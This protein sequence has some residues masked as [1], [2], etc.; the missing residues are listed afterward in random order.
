[1]NRASVFIREKLIG[2][3]GQAFFAGIELQATN[4][5]SRSSL[6]DSPLKRGKVLNILGDFAQRR[7]VKCFAPAGISHFRLQVH[8]TTV[9]WLQIAFTGRA[10]TARKRFR[11]PQKFAQLPIGGNKSNMFLRDHFSQSVRGPLN[12]D[13]NLIFSWSRPE[14]VCVA[15]SCLAIR[16]DRAL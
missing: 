1:M 15:S 9:D 14:S 13:V 8:Q 4:Y 3:N 2:Q 11:A 6:F 10:C 7:F 12:F 5:P 16:A